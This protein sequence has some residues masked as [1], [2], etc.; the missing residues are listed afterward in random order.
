MKIYLVFIIGLIISILESTIFSRLEI[1][2]VVSNISLIY[3]VIVSLI[4][5][6]KLGSFLGLFLGIFRDIFFSPALGANALIYFFIGYSVGMLESKLTKENII[7]PI[8]LVA[9]STIFY[10]ILYLMIMFFLKQNISVFYVFRRIL[11]LEI[12]YNILLTIPLYKILAKPLTV[13]GIRFG[14]K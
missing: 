4:R 5:G 11:V 9:I 1:L 12:L 7:V 10:N 6:K 13:K 8:S 3:I 14:K 2:N